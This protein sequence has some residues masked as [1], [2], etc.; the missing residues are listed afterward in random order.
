VKA[1]Y[2]HG[3]KGKPDH[4][5]FEHA[6]EKE[7]NWVHTHTI[8][9][10]DA[11]KVN[12]YLRAVAAIES[13]KGYRP[14]EVYK[15]MRSVQLKDEDGNSLGDALDAAG[16]K[17]MTPVHVN[18]AKLS[19]LSANGALFLPTK[20]G[21]L[22]KED[23]NTKISLKRP[24][25]E[26]R[27]EILAGILSVDPSTVWPET[28]G[29]TAED[30]DEHAKNIKNDIRVLVE[31][32]AI[33]GR[34]EV[35]KHVLMPL[36]NSTAEYMDKTTEAADGKLL[37]SGILKIEEKAAAGAAKRESIIAKRKLAKPTNLDKWNSITLDTLTA[38]HPD[39]STGE[40]VQLLIDALR[41]LQYRL[42][43]TLH[44]AESF[45]NKVVTACQGSL[46]CRHAVEDPPADLGQLL[47]KLQSSIMAYEKEQQEVVVLRS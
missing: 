11:I 7:D 42:P 27:V 6:N 34:T 14:A 18:N 15:N 25:P 22:L 8:D 17:C 45:H 32:I 9:D 20:P 4:Y 35:P 39:K 26:D 41:E 1:K 47:K 36:L 46:A 12:S 13:A 30:T 24:N 19:A 40:V 44:N 16:G 31:S 43:P 5:R 29:K 37:L 21:A 2:F 33:G 23:P 3:I 10:S 38:K 28:L